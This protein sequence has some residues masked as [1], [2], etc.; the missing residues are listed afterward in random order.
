MSTA[1]TPLNAST[2]MYIGWNAP[3]TTSEY[4]VYMHFAEIQKLKA[5]E[6]RSFNITLNGKLFYGPLVPEY[7]HTNTVYSP[8]ALT[9]VNYTFSLFKNEGSTLPPILNAMEYYRV[10]NFSQSETNGE[11]GT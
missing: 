4:Y 5:N 10:I 3:D 1:G 7:L 6:S 2:P 8:E 11:D 9:G